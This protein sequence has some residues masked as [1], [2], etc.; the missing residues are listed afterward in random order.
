M[1]RHVNRL[2]IIELLLH[3]IRRYYLILILLLG[4][5]LTGVIGFQFYWL[6]EAYRM[7]ELAYQKSIDQALN[8]LIA[9]MD[10][11][12]NRILNNR[13][14]MVNLAS[15]HT[16][17]K[18][19]TLTISKVDSNLMKKLKAIN[20][21]KH[22]LVSRS[23]DAPPLPFTAIE[24]GLTEWLHSQLN[25][26]RKELI[27]SELEPM[28]KEEFTSAQIPTSYTVVVLHHKDTVLYNRNI[29]LPEETAN[30]NRVFKKG[31]FPAAHSKSAWDLHVY[32]NNNIKSTISRMSGLFG[33]S[34]L[35]TLLL[36]VV[37]TLS[38]RLLI[39]NRRLAE[40]RSQM[41]NNLTHELKTPISTIYIAASQISQLNPVTDNDRII[42][43][44][45]IIK[46]EDKR[47]LKHVETVLDLSKSEDR[48]FEIKKEPAMITELVRMAINRFSA[49]IQEKKG[50][51]ILQ[52][53]P[54]L[55][56]LNLD[57][58][59]VLI[60]I[61]NI[62]DNAVKYSSES[63]EIRISIRQ[64]STLTSIAVSDNGI[65]IKGSELDN[66][67]ENFY[68]VPDNNRHHVSGYGIGLSFAKNVIE[69]HS[70]Y[71][72][73][74]SK[75]GIGSTFTINLPNNAHE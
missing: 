49:L 5:G 30:P 22:L 69:K 1:L 45:E 47:I 25:I 62:I 68:R 2:G 12:E 16:G 40:I 64:T 52:E 55:K 38:I 72:A 33:L 41:I 51:L 20:G 56:P 31:I 7:Q 61:E 24:T 4:T 74:T 14:V 35:Y 73:V 46:S 71:I 34:L 17:K 43:F 65:G 54:H 23:G 29:D 50:K 42:S 6:K 11:K 32:V 66:I 9:R 53:D 67:F 13:K 70:G 48:N 26:T 60:A 8:K 10:E 3:M 44:S 19:Q 18:Q 27:V 63:L 75:P 39:K 36:M 57:P 21:D 15:L 58:Q 28:L 59:K 37:F